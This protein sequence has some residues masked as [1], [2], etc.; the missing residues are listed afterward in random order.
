MAVWLDVRVEL[1]VSDSVRVTLGV[2]LCDVDPEDVIDCDCEG[3]RDCD[4][5]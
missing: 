1:A 5:V 3:L 2:W 4:S